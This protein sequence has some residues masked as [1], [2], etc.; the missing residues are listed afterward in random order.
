MADNTPSVNVRQLCLQLKPILG[1]KMDQIYTAYLAEDKEGQQQI[2]HY[3]QLLTAE[4][5]PSKLE[6]NRTVLLPPAK[7]KAEGEYPVGTV[8]YAGK[9]LYD[10]GLREDEWIQHTAIL[11]RS[12]AGKTNIGFLKTSGKSHSSLFMDE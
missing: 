5:L 8:T 2:E 12:G 7:E 6:Q 9:D 10:F 11:G 4:Y 3:L 1:S